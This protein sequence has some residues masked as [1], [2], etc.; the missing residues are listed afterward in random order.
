[1]AGNEV[2]TRTDSAQPERFYGVAVG[3]CP[4][5]YTDWALASL[6]I[7][8]VK[9]PIYRKFPT[10]AEAEHFV[11]TKG[12]ELG[13]VTD[14]VNSGKKKREEA[15]DEEE[16]EEEDEEEED[17]SER[18]NRKRSKNSAASYSRNMDLDVKT[19]KVY[20]DGSARKYSCGARAGVGVF[21]GTNDPRYETYSA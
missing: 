4:G 13:K 11:K 16:K 7:T 21:F 6:Q 3:R 17:I 15:A 2:R 12:N 18:P 8:N 1:M 10:R 14:M 19:I 20:T 5:V 9:R